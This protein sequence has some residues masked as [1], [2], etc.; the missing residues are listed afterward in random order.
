MHKFLDLS[1]QNS[2]PKELS[3]SILSDTKDNRYIKYHIKL[4]SHSDKCKE[5][6]YISFRLCTEETIKINVYFK[7]ERVLELDKTQDTDSVLKL[8]DG[9]FADCL[10]VSS[11]ALAGSSKVLLD[12]RRACFGRT[13]A[14]L[15]ETET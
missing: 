12:R 14:S 15:S 8:L 10:A 5:S 1:R 2:V 4:H 6:S 9:D 3:K 13:F 7:G 11:A